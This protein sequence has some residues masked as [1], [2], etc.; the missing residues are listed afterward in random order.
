M[1]KPIVAITMGDPASIGPEISLKVF[2][3]PKLFERCRPLLVG[4]ASVLNKVMEVLPDRKI[5]LHI[6][7][8]VSEA[9]FRPGTMDV[10]DMGLVDVNQLKFG[11]VSKMAGNAAFAYVKKVID[12]AMDKQVDATVTNAL[13]KEA[14]NLAGHHFA[15]HT[16]IYAHY[17]HTKNYTMML[18]H[19]NVRVVH[20][21]THVSLREA[22][23]LVKKPRVAEVIRIANDACK[24][25]GIAEPKIGVAG[26]NPHSSENGLFGSEEAEEIIPA[27]NQTKA[28][29]I[30]V[31]GPVPPDTIFPK[32]VGGWYDIVVAMYH[33]QG[34]IPLKLLG[35]KYDEVKQRWNSVAG[36]NITLGLPIVRTSVDHGTAFDQ[37]LKGTANEIS[38]E[39]AIDYA[40][41]LAK[42]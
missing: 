1:E 28:E 31:E 5:K 24:R 12:L 29:G 37:S 32:A 11:V 14:M 7:N 27:I 8:S 3:N 19:G 15:G 21:S 23:D 34:H 2:Q 25:L 22:C 20:N 6:I 10:L 36:V 39:N 26:L 4:D 18:A 40:I 35:F 41:K 16:E 9:L 17:T 33:D 13:N 42:D 38:L 30:N